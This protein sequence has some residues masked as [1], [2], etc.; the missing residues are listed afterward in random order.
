MTSNT[1]DRADILALRLPDPLAPIEVMRAWYRSQVFPRHHHPYYTIGIIRH[2]VGT[3]WCR[4]VTLALHPGDAVVIAPGDAH[5]GASG[6]QATLIYTA[7]HVPADL[8]IRHGGDIASGLANDRRLVAELCLLDEAIARHDGTAAA[9]AAISAISGLASLGDRRHVAGL[10]RPVP[11]FV[12]EVKDLIEDCFADSTATTL[13]RLAA[14][15]GVSPFHLVREFTRGIG[16]SPHQYLVQTRVCRAR[17]LL[18]TAERISDVAI[19]VGFVDQSHLTLH[20]RRHFGITPAAFR[21]GF[22]V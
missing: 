5:T 6:T 2:G 9:A 7:M 13:G 8:V 16:L 1:R 17:E 11:P 22:L 19:T 18:P 20:F 10:E 3:L 4:G 15:A 21:R 12:Q 14:H